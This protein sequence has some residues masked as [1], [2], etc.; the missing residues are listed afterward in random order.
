MAVHEI[1]VNTSRLSQDVE[2]MEYAL[3]RIENQMD[4]MFDSV[5]QLDT[6]WD[7]PA[8]DAFYIQFAADYEQMRELC[9]ILRE[10]IECCRFAGTEYIS[11]ENAVN[12]IVNAIRI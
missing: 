2:E 5:N 4:S 3:R 1:A 7:G 10:L 12:G 8:N 11:C 9:R 6:M